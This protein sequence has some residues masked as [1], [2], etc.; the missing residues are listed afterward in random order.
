MPTPYTHNA[1]AYRVSFAAAVMLRGGRTTRSFDTCFEMWDGDEVA[2]AIWRRSLK[3]PKLAA[4]LP[5]YID[6]A[7]AKDAYD[8]LQ[9]KDLALEAAKTRAAREAASEAY[10]AKIETAKTSVVRSHFD[11][12]GCDPPQ[13]YGPTGE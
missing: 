13:W 10:F 5:K 6:A 2:A 12:D 8:R 4:A 9:G 3:N 7:M 11:R 1:F